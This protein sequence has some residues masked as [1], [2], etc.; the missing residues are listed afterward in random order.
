MVANGDTM[1]LAVA[2]DGRVLAFTAALS[3]VACLVS[4]LAPAVQ[5]VRVQVNPA[6]KEARTDARGS[7]RLGRVLVVAQLAISM[8]L[9]VGATLFVGTLVNLYAVDRGFDSNGLLIVTLRSSQAYS[10]ERGGAVKRAMIERLRA[11]PGIRAASATQVLPVSGSLWTKEIQVEGHVSRSGEAD[12]SAFNIVGPA[13]F[14]TLGT[15][16]V[17]GREFDDRD[18]ARSPKVA[19]VNETFARYFFGASPAIGRRVTIA[20]A[21]REIVGV[22]RDAKYR[23]LREAATRTTYVPWMQREGDQ[24]ADYAFLAR[25]ATGDPLRFASNME[26]LV[27][28]VDPAL[29]VRATFSYATLVDR[30][31]VTERIMATLGGAFGLLALIV[32]GLGLFGVLAF[33]VTRRTNELGLRMALGATPWAATRLVLRQVAWIVLPGIAIGAG[34]ALLLTGLARNILFELTPTDPRMFLVA[35]LVLAMA[36]ALAAWLPAR[37]AARVDPLIALRH[38]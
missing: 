31:L 16:L 4:G 19:V 33:Q 22:V 30:S 24:P 1:A 20:G 13:Y 12:T 37:R 34:G 9:I 29:H 35:A 7:H 8:V 36:A 10:D 5:A 18:R 25:A 23:N 26:R 3:L 38:D 14:S 28:G 2:P 15:P 32:A 11:V 6:L 27:R 21:A 17:S